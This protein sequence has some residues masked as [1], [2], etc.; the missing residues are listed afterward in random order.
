MLGPRSDLEWPEPSA[1]GGTRASGLTGPAAMGRAGIS[2]RVAGV[3]DVAGQGAGRRHLRAAEVHLVALGARAAREV[4]GEGAQ[5][6]HA[7]GR[8]L[9]H[10]DAAQAAGLVQYARRIP[11][12][13]AQGAVGRD[14]GQG[15]ARAGID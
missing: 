15:L 13:S 4:A 5:A 7:G 12:R 11:S 6:G 10:A 1:G 3:G 9:A 2:P 8:G 14:L